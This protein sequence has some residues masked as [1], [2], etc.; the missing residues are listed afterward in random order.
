MTTDFMIVIRMCIVVKIVRRKHS[1]R[2]LA[3]LFLFSSKQ[4]A[5]REDVDLFYGLP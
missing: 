1:V 3:S 2:K 4:V 5:E